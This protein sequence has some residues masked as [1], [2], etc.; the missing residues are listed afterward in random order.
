M[1]MRIVTVVCTI[2]IVSLIT[3]VQELLCYSEF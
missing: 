2:D 3:N 1:L